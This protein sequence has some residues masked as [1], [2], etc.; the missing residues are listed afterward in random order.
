[1]LTLADGVD[2]TFS[3]VHVLKLQVA[4]DTHDF[5]ALRTPASQTFTTSGAVV[6]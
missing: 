4:N 1:M 6:S 3:L 2:G 5:V